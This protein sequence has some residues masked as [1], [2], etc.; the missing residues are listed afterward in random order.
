MRCTLNVVVIVA[1]VSLVGGCGSSSFVS[2]RYDNFT[3]YYNKFYNAQRSFKD[4]N[5][6][7][8]A[9]RPVDRQLLLTVFPISERSAASREYESAI[10]KSADVL[11]SH[12]GSKWVDD[13]LMLIGRSYFNQ[14]NFVS[15]EQ[16]F[17]EVMA[18]D[19]KL[20]DE[21]RYWLA[22]SQIA[23]N[24]YDGAHATVDAALAGDEV[25]R[26]WRPYLYLARGELAVREGQYE[27]AVEP[28]EAG[29]SVREKRLAARA[30]FLLGQVYEKLGDPEKAI[31]SYRAV[32]KHKPQ[33][34]LEFAAQV[35]A[36]EVSAMLGRTEEADRALRRMERDDKN[37]D[38]RH[39]LAVVRARLQREARDQR[40]AQQTLLGLL[41][42]SDQPQPHVRG[43]AHYELARLYRDVFRDFERAAA[44]FDT[45][46]TS[47]QSL[48]VQRE[49]FGQV[50]AIEDPFAPG[51]IEDVLDEQ[52]VFSSFAMVAKEI[53]RQDSLLNLGTMDEESFRARIEEIRQIRIEE[54]KERER[55]QEELDIQGQFRDRAGAQGRQGLPEGKVI[56]YDPDA[57]A[58][59]FL[60][61]KEPVRVQ[62]AF[63]LFRQ[64]WGDRPHVPGWRVSSNISGVGVQAGVAD[65]TLLGPGAGRGDDRYAN[66]TV[67]I[68]D[69][70]RSR[71]AQQRMI[72]ERAVTRYEMGNALFLAM[73]EADSAAHW[74]QLIIREDPDQP[75]AARAHYALSQVYRT[76]D[77]DAEADAMLQ[78]MRERYPDMD[79]TVIEEAVEE[80]AEGEL[81]DDPVAD[82]AYDEAFSR[83]QRGD[84]G[85]AVLDMLA[86]AAGHPE[87]TVAPRALLAVGLIAGDWA[88]EDS[89][90]LL[91]PL[92]VAV[93]DSLLE[94]YGWQ[95]VDSMSTEEEDGGL[96]GVVDSTDGGGART[97]D[98]S[99]DEQ[100]D[101]ADVDPA[102]VDSAVV[103]PAAADPAAAVDPAAVDPAVIDAV[104]DDIDGAA[105]DS[106]FAVAD[107]VAGGA[108]LQPDSVESGIPIR[109][110][111]VREVY[112]YLASRYPASAAAQ[113][114]AR[115]AIALNEEAAARQAV[116]DSLAQVAAEAAAVFA[117]IDSLARTDS[118][119]AGIEAEEAALLT[120][121]AS[122]SV[123]MAVPGA[124]ADSV[125]AVA[126]D[127]TPDDTIPDKGASDSVRRDT[128][129]VRAAPVI[130]PA[131]DVDVEPQLIGGDA[132][133]MR[134]IGFQNLAEAV[135][136]T[137]ELSFV[138]NTDGRVSQ[139]VVTKG[140]SEDADRE[141]LR[142]MYQSRFRPG[143][144]DNQPVAVR[145]T[146]T[147]EIAVE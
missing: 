119:F 12:E 134:L 81:L 135:S 110:P 24:Q 127:T 99:G 100:A 144:K 2:H 83:W 7:Q 27:D 50:Q 53:S 101:S 74:Y 104:P 62:E 118:L 32:R 140:L 133:F 145:M 93:P 109:G 80:E 43:A 124:T 86:N 128:V 49:T 58:A 95:A 67:D 111:D 71:S 87:A 146:K 11:R 18:L 30:Q 45:A 113:Q 126:D 20:K 78:Q 123:T 138:V 28:L 33:Y 90:D 147:V 73:A 84:Y 117:R 102:A 9:S 130:L 137:V 85:A 35:R 26:R 121:A 66:V 82:A 143:L 47:L 29:L 42:A 63:Q 88:R 77:R 39:D 54:L 125:A 36:I 92:P 107:S 55:L 57:A 21:A 8:I 112:A 89:L 51:A 136:G 19:T 103:D 10:R 15:A 116:L 72:A 60:F 139:V 56:D 6:R 115:T 52:A 68:S 132:A 34:E 23:G 96:P 1:V 70:P 75:V 131:E 129:D 59:G 17:R 120:E 46:A 76:L 14:Q 94:Y 79:P 142:A 25:S 48:I 40:G 22:R 108:A 91:Q 122:D 16:K 105:A 37:Y 3:A 64:R 61:H 114:A 5:R 13:A 31:D 69:I 4:A 65:S 97:V 141:V 106:L 41:R 98:E 44:H 38:Y